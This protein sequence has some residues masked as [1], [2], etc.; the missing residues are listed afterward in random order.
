VPL[1]QELADV[2]PPACAGGDRAT[3]SM[4][5]CASKASKMSTLAKCLPTYSVPVEAALYSKLSEYTD[6]QVKQVKHEN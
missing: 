6:E 2:W 5:V 4:Y 1:G 3:L